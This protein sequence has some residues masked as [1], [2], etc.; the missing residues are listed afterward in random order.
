MFDDR[1]SFFFR[2]CRFFPHDDD[3]LFPSVA[4]KKGVAFLVILRKEKR[5]TTS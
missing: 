4:P 3:V 1:S 5:E 2:F